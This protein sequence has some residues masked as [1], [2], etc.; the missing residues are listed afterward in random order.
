[1]TKNKKQLR[2]LKNDRR[3]HRPPQGYRQ[4]TS[5]VVDAGGSWGGVLYAGDLVRFI[6]LEGRHAV[7]FLCYNATT[8]ATR[9]QYAD[10]AD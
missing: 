2:P 3:I 10:P 9:N 5:I 1:M 7:D 6:D 4:V 8:C